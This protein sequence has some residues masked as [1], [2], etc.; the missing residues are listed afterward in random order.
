[1]FNSKKSINFAVQF[2]Y[3]T[4]LSIFYLII[5]VMCEYFLKFGA[6]ETKLKNFVKDM[7][8]HQLVVENVLIT[9]L[10]EIKKKYIGKSITQRI[11]N[12]INNGVLAD[13]PCYI[14]I[15]NSN[16]YVN[17]K[18]MEVCFKDNETP[19]VYV[20]VTFAYSEIRK[21][22]CAIGNKFDESSIDAIV[23]IINLNRKLLARYQDA[24]KNVKKQWKKMCK[25]VDTFLKTMETSNPMFY[26]YDAANNLHN[27]RSSNSM[28]YQDEIDSKVPLFVA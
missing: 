21:S 7:S 12:S 6:D 2:G 1:M 9:V 11:A 8:E 15:K 23:D 28:T 3:C 13:S 5:G 26:E 17:E 25:A 22:T 16:Y 10:N 19:Y 24:A 4:R 18:I 14:E 20:F 27:F